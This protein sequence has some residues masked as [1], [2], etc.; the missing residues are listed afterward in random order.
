[1]KKLM[2]LLLLL[3][4]T[5]QPL[6]AAGV[7][8]DTVKGKT[9]SEIDA[10]LTK[11]SKDGYSGSV[12]IASRGEIILHKGYGLANRE[13]GIA[14]TPA[15]LYNVASLGKLFTAVAILQLETKGKLKTSDLLSKY[16]GE[17][18]KEKSE[19]TIHH[20]LTHT[21][22]LLPDG[23]QLDYSS[24][25]AFIQ[26]VKDAPAEAKPGEKYRYTNA[27]YTLLAAIV[28]EVSGLPFEVYLQRNILDPAGLTSTGFAWDKRFTNSP[29]AIGY[30]GK[31]L[32]E[33]SPVPP[34]AD[35]WGARG[36]GNLITTTGDLYKWVQA[37]R[38]N[39][40]LAEAAGKKMLTAY[41]RDEGYGW[42][43][44]KTARGTTLA[45]KGG[46]RP[47]FESEARWY[48]DEDVVVLY[49]INNHIGFRVPIYQGIERIIWNK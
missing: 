12:L 32:D 9:G 18:P 3:C 21:A 44:M 26:S 7:R 46:G 16:L 43:V 40:V 10:F 48:L 28:E 47:E 22:G 31:K 5:L 20:L 25:K 17:F 19:A 34:Q 42:H 30:K 1:M 33:L 49:T 11:L 2:G 45:R 41:V 4:L 15:T 6:S 14:N 38:N 35:V 37:L 39:V 29:V 36:P 23:A 8:W 13:R 24:R 27:G